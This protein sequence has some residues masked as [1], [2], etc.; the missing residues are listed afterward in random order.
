MSQENAA[1]QPSPVE[2]LCRWTEAFNEGDYETTLALTADDI[3]YHELEGMPG[4]RGMAGVYNGKDDVT[5]WFIEF[6]GGWES[7]FRNDPVETTE[8]EDGRVLRVERW[9]GRG[10]KSAVEVEMSA[11]GLYTV[12]D[13][14]VT[15]C[16]YFKTKAKALEAVGLSE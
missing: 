9:R 7:G 4:A 5:R 8:L 13:G 16:R 10:L 3:E 15:C 11:L 6:L 14:K 12:R 2:V 1:R